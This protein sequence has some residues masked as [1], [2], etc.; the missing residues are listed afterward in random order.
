MDAIPSIRDGKWTVVLTTDKPAFFVWAD[1]PHIPGTFSDNSFTLYPGQPVRLT[2]TPKGNESFDA[3][4][5][6]LTV[7][8]LRQTYR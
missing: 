4:K 5:S 1:T 2:F 3:F 7:K 6:A 8:H